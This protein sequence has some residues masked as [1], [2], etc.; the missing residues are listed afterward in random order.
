M[1]STMP[2]KPA[3][4]QPKSQV[5]VP[6]QNTR[7]AL[8]PWI[9]RSHRLTRALWALITALLGNLRLDQPPS[10]ADHGLP[11]DLGDH[12]AFLLISFQLVIDQQPP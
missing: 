7:K 9:G 11:A 10:T 4:N 2:G 1:A 5:I 8:C 3:S 6:L 12:L